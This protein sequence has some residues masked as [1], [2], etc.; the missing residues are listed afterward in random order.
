MSARPPARRREYF[1]GCI[2][3]GRHPVGSKLAVECPVL[4]RQRRRAVKRTAK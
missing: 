4:R 2:V 3:D 1:G